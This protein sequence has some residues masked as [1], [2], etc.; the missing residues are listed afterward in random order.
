MPSFN[1][2]ATALANQSWETGEEIYVIVENIWRETLGG[3]VWTTP[4]EEAGV[5]FNYRAGARWIIARQADK[6]LRNAVLMGD[7]K[8]LDRHW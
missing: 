7:E 6:P 2:L 5:R 3:W 4:I 8:R 1:H